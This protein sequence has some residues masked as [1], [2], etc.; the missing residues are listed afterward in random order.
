MMKMTMIMIFKFR[1]GETLRKA[2][3]EQPKL[4]QKE[5][6][7]EEAETARTKLLILFYS[8]MSQS[9]STTFCQNNMLLLHELFFLLDGIQ[10]NLLVKSFC[11]IEEY[12]YYKYNTLQHKHTAT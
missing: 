10:S 5:R 4:I 6:K 2:Y 9:G 1:L 8:L 12:T 3:K 11:Y 7:R